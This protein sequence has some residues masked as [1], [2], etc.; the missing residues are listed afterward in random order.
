MGW[1][2]F[3]LGQR[4]QL[5][6]AHRYQSVAEGDYEVVRYLPRQDD[7]VRY[8]V[9]HP[10]EPHEKGGDGKRVAGAVFSPL[11]ASGLLCASV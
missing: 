2:K 1:H 8:R 4:V 3:R 7:E 10:R 9:K 11:R 6:L 5:N